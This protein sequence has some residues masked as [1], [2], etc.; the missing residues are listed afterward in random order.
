MKFLD[1]ATN[2]RGVIG[3]EIKH[4]ILIKEPSKMGF[5]ARYGENLAHMLNSAPPS[6][7]SCLS[8][9]CRRQL[10]PHLD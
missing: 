6:L 3:S 8:C 1:F 7:T 5:V 2:D 4:Q 10:C 9:P